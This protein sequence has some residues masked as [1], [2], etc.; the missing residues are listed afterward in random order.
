MISLQITEPAIQ[1]VGLLSAIPIR[2]N[3][4]IIREFQLGD[5]KELF[6]LHRDAKATRYAGGTRTQEESLQSL[7][8]IISRVRQTGFGAFALELPDDGDLIGWA[9]V[10]KMIDSDRYEIIYALKPDYWGQGL[11]TEAGQA[12]LDASFESR[13]L[14]EIFA[15]V[16]PQNIGS[17]RVLEKLGLS[18]VDYSFDQIT[19]RHACLYRISKGKFQ[20]SKASRVSQSSSKK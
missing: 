20:R 8:R 7:Y 16:F 13:Q 1:N 6:S 12:L 15:L 18:F 19:Q 10:Q 11:A 17:I 9:G 5:A 14:T 3:R 4:L 2:T